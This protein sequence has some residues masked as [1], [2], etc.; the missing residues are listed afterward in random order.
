MCF[1]LAELL[2]F[3]KGNSQHIEWE[4]SSTDVCL[5]VQTQKPGAIT[6]L[7]A[8]VFPYLNDMMTDEPGSTGDKDSLSA[9]ILGLEANAR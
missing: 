7:A 2:M 4:S 6:F 9:P 1:L 5:S 8:K 3:S